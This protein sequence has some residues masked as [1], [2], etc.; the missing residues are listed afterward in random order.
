MNL[1]ASTTLPLTAT[2]D[3]DVAQNLTNQYAG[4]GTSGTA[5]QAEWRSDWSVAN[6]VQCLI[7]ADGDLYNRNGTYGT[8]SDRKFKVEESIHDARDY[9]DDLRRI[10]PQKYLNK[11]VE[12]ERLG[13]VAQEVQKVKPGFVKEATFTTYERERVPEYLPRKGRKGP[14]QQIGYAW[15]Y[16]RKDGK[17]VGKTEEALA[18]KTALFIPMLHSGWLAHD[19]RL[20]ALEARVAE[21]EA[22]LAAL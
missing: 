15:T 16:K 7:Q 14:R 19:E 4:N 11:N 17:R 5:T 8:I 10:R 13:Y 1:S 6:Q 22:Q 9:S 2:F 21:L 3:C 20:F 18:V 12:G